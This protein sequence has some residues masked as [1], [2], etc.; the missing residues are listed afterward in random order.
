MKKI[1]L[2]IL[3]TLLLWSN[4][5]LLEP[6]YKG[7][8]NRDGIE[9]GISIEEDKDG[10]RTLIVFIGTKKGGFKK[11][12]SNS[13]LVLR[14]DEGGGRGDPFMAVVIK[15]GYFS[16]EHYGGAAHRWKIITTFKYSKAKKD[17]FLH[18]DSFGTYVDKED[19]DEIKWNIKTV[20]DFG[21]VS[22]ENYD[23][24]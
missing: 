18:K 14:A 9:D 13:K 10:N 7:D 6:D 11:V 21:V 4:Q 3:A 22:F 1:L 19:L 16:V 5:N 17:W 8:L 20:K 24:K 12:A 15:N 23:K 2:I